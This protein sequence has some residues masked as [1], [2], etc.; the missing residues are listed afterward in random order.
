[1]GTIEIDYLKAVGGSRVEWTG[2]EQD[3][4]EFT[5]LHVFSFEPYACFTY[6]K[7][8]LKGLR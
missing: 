6:S 5:C 4:S 3:V 2:W 7:I 8:K 1:M